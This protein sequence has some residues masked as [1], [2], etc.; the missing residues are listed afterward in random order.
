LSSIVVHME[1]RESRIERLKVIAKQHFLLQEPPASVDFSSDS[2]LEYRR[3]IKADA[4]RTRSSLLSLSERGK[5]ESMLTHYCRTERI[6]YK[7]GLNEVLAP[8][9]L[10]Q[11]EGLTDA[12]CYSCFKAFVQ[13]YLL[14]WY[15]DQDFRMLRAA[16][17]VFRLMLKY[18]DSRFSLY[19]AN[20]NIGPELYSTPWFLTIFASKIADANLV[21]A[22]WEELMA[23]RDQMFVIYIA[24]ALLFVNRN[25]ILASEPSII[26][27][28]TSQLTINTEEDL[29]KILA[30]AKELMETTPPSVEVYF[31]N[32]RLDCDDGIDGKLAFLEKEFCVSVLPSEIVQTC[33][34]ALTHVNCQTGTCRYCQ[35]ASS[36]LN[37][38]IIDCRTAEEQ[39]SC[40]LPNTHLLEPEAYTDQEIMSEIPDRFISIRGSYHIV[41]L[42]SGPFRASNFT[43]DYIE[44]AEEEVD[45]VQNMMENLLLDFQ[46]KGFP[47]VS[48][49][50]G[51]FAECHHYAVA[52]SCELERHAEDCRYCR[53][54]TGERGENS[55]GT[56]MGKVKS[57]FA[58]LKAL[59]KR[60]TGKGEDQEAVSDEPPT[61][62]PAVSGSRVVIL[63]V[64]SRQ[65]ELEKW[66]NDPSTRFYACK[67]YDK[68]IGLCYPEDR[69]L[70]LTKHEIVISTPFS[71]SPADSGA[72]VVGT[73]EESAPLLSLQKIASKKS[74]A[75]VLSFYFSQL[76]E[77]ISFSY[78][79]GDTEEAKDCI[80]H[81]QDLIKQLKKLD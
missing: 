81:T 17:F 11:R 9:L 73:V 5:L 78:G 65:K 28:T 59:A 70:V 3:V 22:L 62:L 34:P 8:F 61:V 77:E 24:L 58:G 32:M 47:Y 12:E 33:Y 55:K 18:H 63:K 31:A 39:A 36:R 45:V 79:F 66:Q 15:I 20:A 57:V 52:L 71:M 42:G 67:K 10:L 51:G 40:T 48:I 76:D 72:L 75:K 50:Q 38:V 35:K 74:N 54:E 37:M 21:L 29:V 6:R 46:R 30:K 26:L 2:D 64:K 80:S 43:L 49:V 14:P 41:L 27:V 23:S 60:Y 16:F 4:D 56:V 19:L 69:I 1:G 68:L 25:Q 44:Q 53:N 13:Q 7:Q